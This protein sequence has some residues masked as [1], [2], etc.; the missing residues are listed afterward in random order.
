MPLDVSTYTVARGWVKNDPYHDLTGMNA[1]YESLLMGRQNL[2]APIPAP[3]RA[4]IP[5]P[6]RRIS[7]QDVLDSTP[8]VP[9]AKLLREHVQ[10]FKDVR[11]EWRA[12]RT[13][14]YRRF[15]ARL[16]MCRVHVTPFSVYPDQMT[17]PRA[18]N[19]GYGHH[20]M[21]P[22]GA[23][24]TSMAGVVPPGTQMNAL[25]ALAT[26]A[27]GGGARAAPGPAS[28]MGSMGGLLDLASNACAARASVGGSNDNS[29]HENALASLMALAATA[30]T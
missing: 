6:I 4:V 14:V 12:K 25:D 16:A 24:T 29:G 28:S 23:H 18:G 17:D 26:R 2:P 7:T 9:N 15:Q 22:H 8:A 10:R 5:A 13:R 11:K 1:E 3:P 20:G 27:V 30:A 21:A 19:T